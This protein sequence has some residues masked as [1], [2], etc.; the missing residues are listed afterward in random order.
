VGE[1]GEIVTTRLGRSSPPGQRFEGWNE[2]R[3]EADASRARER[4]RA[5]GRF[6]RNFI[7]QGTAAEWA[8]CWMA[9]I[10]RRLRELDD[11]WFTDAPHLVFFLHDEVV[12]HTPAELADQVSVI[13]AEAAAEAGR[14]LFGDLPVTFPLTIVSVDNYGQA[15]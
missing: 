5:W 1:R 2:T 7:V 6:T 10:R 4:S 14:L 15:K 11:G 3:T 13:L 12:V 8:L 9:S